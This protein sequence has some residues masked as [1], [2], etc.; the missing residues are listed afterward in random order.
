MHR[1]LLSAA[2]GIIGAA[3]NGFGVTGVAP[4]VSLFAL[5]V[6]DGA[7]RGTLSA[8]LDALKWVVSPD[9]QSQGIRVINLSLASY[10]SPTNSDYNTT[11]QWF[12]EV[13]RELSDAGVM[14]IAA[15]GNYGSSLYGYLPASCPV[16]AAVTALDVD[17]NMPASFSNYLP[18]KATPYD[19]ARTFAGPGVAV[20][21]TM[22]T[23]QTS[24]NLAY[25]YRELSG[26]SQAAP[27]VAGVA[28]TC[29]MSGACASGMTGQQ[30]LLV[31]RAA[32]M[33]RLAATNKRAYGFPGDGITGGSVAAST[34]YSGKL[35]WA[36]YNQ[37]SDS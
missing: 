29:V 31:L 12:C 4:G 16:V 36:K 13:F 7:G 10:L 28:A 9:G 34:K 19:K 35:I 33:E 20:L 15:A 27:H 24:V 30:Q 17:Q 26:T 2:G 37:V 11:L 22:S 25:P 23:A 3:N 18:A 14:L 1:V 6:L 5:K 21:S 8:V 32:A